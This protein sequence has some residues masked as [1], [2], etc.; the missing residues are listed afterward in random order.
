MT[1][2]T[3]ALNVKRQNAL[4]QERTIKKRMKKA[5]ERNLRVDYNLIQICQIILYFG[6][7]QDLLKVLKRLWN[8]KMVRLHQNQR[9]WQPQWGKV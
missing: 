7:K 8:Q 1:V 4:K 2:L 6:V 5:K 3:T 9:K